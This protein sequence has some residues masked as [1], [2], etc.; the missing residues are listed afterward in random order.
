MGSAANARVRDYLVVTLIDMGLS[1]QT[2][3]AEVP[4]YFG[5]AGETVEITNV[6]VRIE[7]T[8]GDQAMVLTAHYDSVPTTPG[9]ND[10]AAAV[11]AL[12][13][14]GRELAAQP[15]PN[16]VILLFTDGEEP[17]P[18]FGASAFVD[19]PWF[20]DVTLAV[21]FEGIGVAGP[22]L[23]VE[24][25]GPAAELA[26][27][28]A[29][30][31]RHPAMF[32]FLTRT[33][34]LIGGAS[35]DFDVFRNADI[36]GYNFAYLRGSSVYHTELDRPARLNLDGMAHQATLAKE[37]AYGSRET[38]GKPDAGPQVFF[39]I[40]GWI[41]IGYGSGPARASA[42]LAAVIVGWLVIQRMR[43]AP[44]SAKRLGAGVALALTASLAAVAIT[45][46]V[47]IGIVA[48]R[49]GM[50]V[51]ESYAWLLVLVAG[52]TGSWYLI[53]RRALSWKVDLL[54]AIALLWGLLALL[55]GFG[56]PS[57]SY[58]FVWPA[59]VG[60]VMMV[61]GGAPPVRFAIIA[62]PT[63]VLLIPAIDSFFLLAAPRPGNPGSELPATIAVSLLL[64][65]LAVGLVH[66]ASQPAA[67]RASVWGRQ[68]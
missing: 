31:T 47:W 2:Q 40:P 65:I 50:G 12:L 41:V 43:R 39:T 1:P 34:E 68:A 62:I 7:G 67:R 26:G 14:T 56:L 13:E 55:S 64:V 23:L 52:L 54:T 10:N 20:D 33:A 5:A 28:L 66:A 9:A 3:T 51:L 38:S 60:G 17:T 37:I 59:I 46:V 48:L 6:L 24:L 29:D 4:D 32:S 53:W 18:R 22:A 63:A 21:N 42:L 30:S 27:R 16:D 58:L 11:A 61:A 8:E 25:N 49:S 57:M 44:G 45:T 35:T 36:P 15:P 19:H